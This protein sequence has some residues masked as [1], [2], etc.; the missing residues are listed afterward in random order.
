MRPDNST[1]IK[2]RAKAIELFKERDFDSVTINDICEACGISKH[3]FYYYFASKEGLLKTVM[4]LPE[5]LSSDE[6]AKLILID[7]PYEQYRELLKKRVRHFEN[8]G[9]DIVKKIL[10]ARLTVSFD[11]QK[12]K[13]DCDDGK[14]FLGMQINL[15]KKAQERGEILN[16]SDPKNLVQAAFCLLIGISQVWATHPG[17][18]FNLEKEYF[19]ILDS[20]MM[21]A[22]GK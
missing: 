8:C 3:T 16:D 9:K 6:T 15:I 12:E 14:P 17:T 7:S 19:V 20:L 18:K 13:E 21:K 11:Q 2:I 22:K 10:V 4:S 1:K 5:Q